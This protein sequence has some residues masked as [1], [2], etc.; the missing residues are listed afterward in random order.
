[1][2]FLNLYQPFFFNFTIKTFIQILYFI[3]YSFVYL[4]INIKLGLIS[5]YMIPIKKLNKLIKHQNYED[6]F[7][8]Y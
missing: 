3:E 7:Q 8:V 6:S 5:L 4:S 1:M 2:V